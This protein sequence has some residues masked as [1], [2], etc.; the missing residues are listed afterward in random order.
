MCE[1]IKKVREYRESLDDYLAYV[2][3]S[4]GDR[5]EHLTSVYAAYGAHNELPIYRINEW[6][7]EAEDKLIWDVDDYL[8][9]KYD[10]HKTEQIDEAFDRALDTGEIYECG[11]EFFHA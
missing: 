3:V 4:I 1:D 7:L 6:Y 10:I 2:N 11:G 9:R 8:I 5:L